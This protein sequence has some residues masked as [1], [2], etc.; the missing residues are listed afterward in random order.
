MISENELEKAKN[1]RQSNYELLRILAMFGI[2]LYHHFGNKTPNGFIDLP[3]GFT[4][5][6]Y[7]YDI[8]N[9]TSFFDFKTLILDFCYGHF[10]QGGNLIFMLI[11][12]YFLFGKELNFSKR[13]KSVYKILFITAFWGCLLTI[14]TTLIVKFLYPLGGAPL[15][16]PVFNFLSWFSSSNMWYFQAYGIFIL[17]IIPILKY[18][19]PRIDKKTHISI[20][21]MFIALFFLDYAQY[22]PNIWLSSKILQFV[23]CYYIG[24]YVSKYSI[25]FS[26][27]KL[28]SVLVIYIMLF[29]AYEYYWRAS[30]RKMYEPFEYSYISVMEPFISSLIFSVLVFLIFSKINFKSRIINCIA[31]TTPGIYVFHYVLIDETFAIANTYWWNDWSL[32]GYCKFILIDSILLFVIGY[33]LDS[34][35]KWLFSVLEKRLKIEE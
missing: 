32:G 8:V 21:A 24:G 33:I 19:E 12:G 29:F 18:F 16:K 35:R 13:V 30:M 1:V 31:S 4:Q 9:N 11:T 17:V 25:Q 26:L 22:L 27:K 34:V 15:F 10:G 3:M 28:L 14:I 23:L 2:V 6:N 5:E 20:I 7:F